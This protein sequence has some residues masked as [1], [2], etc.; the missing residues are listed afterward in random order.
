[1]NDPDPGGGEVGLGVRT[2]QALL[3]LGAGAALLLALGL[4]GYEVESW[5]SPPAVSPDPEA[6]DLPDW[7]G[8]AHA[9]MIL[10]LALLV[11]ATAPL[12]LA[13]RR[14][15]PRL[16]LLGLGVVA[17]LLV[18]V[19]AIYWTDVRGNDS[20][21]ELNGSVLG[22]PAW[23]AAIVVCGTTTAGARS[24]SLSRSGAL[25][26]L[27][28]LVIAAAAT[29]AA[30][31]GVCLLVAEQHGDEVLADIARGEPRWQD[32]PRQGCTV[33]ASTSSG[34]RATLECRPLGP[35]ACACAPAPTRRFHL[36]LD[37]AGRLRSWTAS[38][39]FGGVARR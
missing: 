29:L 3:W 11:T 26:T 32:L 25:V 15:R 16:A 33:T 38:Q 5:L 1:M 27:H 30:A 8:A 20:C 39:G 22:L 24:L 13:L 34:Q 19:S 21:A 4:V 18:S 37:E 7:S 23:L 28:W 12:L 2:R 14:P 17:L 36:A 6:S 35:P 31:D 9:A 10:L